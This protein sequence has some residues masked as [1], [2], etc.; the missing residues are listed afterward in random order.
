VSTQYEEG[1]G[2]R[3]AGRG[4]ASLQCSGA[5]G[6]AGLFRGVRGG[7]VRG[8]RGERRAERLRAR[9]GLCVRGLAGYSRRG[10]QAPPSSY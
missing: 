10:A 9:G 8:L 4:R 3:A 7:G 5:R 1:G 2:G 6:E